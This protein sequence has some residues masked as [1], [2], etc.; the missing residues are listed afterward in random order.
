MFIWSFIMPDASEFVVCFRIWRI[1]LL[2]WQGGTRLL[3]RTVF[4]YI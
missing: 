3:F 4:Y 2:N 1:V